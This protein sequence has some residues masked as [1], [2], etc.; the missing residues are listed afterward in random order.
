[1]KMCD[2]L[3]K[4]SLVTAN[5]G[6]GE[7]FA[8]VLGDWVSFLGGRP[9]EIVVVDAGSPAVTQNVLRGLR[10]VGKIDQL[11]LLEQ[12]HP[13]VGKENCFIQEHTAAGLAT[14]PYL[15]FFKSDTLV[16]REGNEEWLMRA[17]ELLERGDTF[18]VSGS[19]NRPCR[20]REVEMDSAPAP[21][22]ALPRSTRGGG[23]M[24]DAIAAAEWYFTEKCSLNFALMKRDRYLAAIEEFGGEYVASGFT[25]TSPLPDDGKGSRR[26]F[27]EAAWEAYMKNHGLFTLA[28]V[29]DLAW[30]IFHTNV[31]GADLVGV[32][33]D[34]LA[35]RDVEKYMNAGQVV[36]L[37]G[38][39]YYGMK[40]DRMKEWRVMLGATPL[41][42]PWRALKRLVF[43]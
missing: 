3:E 33:R 29:E 6:N 20:H 11:L 24:E 27:I 31:Q 23:K 37:H 26:Y 13:R 9:G 17:M 15:L 14:R 10:E 12:D 41:G 4:V 28:R 18:A 19:F 22:P 32:R 16:Y 8:D 42:K 30:T 2:A 38:G 21:T 25:S 1:M 40:R 5:Y 36:E 7:T 39:C 34:F 43:G 35:R